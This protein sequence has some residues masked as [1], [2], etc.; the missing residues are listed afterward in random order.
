MIQGSKGHTTL[1]VFARRFARPW[2]Q[3]FARRCALGLTTAVCRTPPRL[4]VASLTI[5]LTTGMARADLT[6]VPQQGAGTNEQVVRVAPPE[7]Y[8]AF[9]VNDPKSADIR[10]GFKPGVENAT[11]LLALYIPCAELKA[12]TEAKTGWLPEWL[13]YETNTIVF[14]DSDDPQDPI[15]MQSRPRGQGAVAQLCIDAQVGHPKVA[16]ATFEAQ[17]A[18]A[19]MRL[20]IDTPV[21]YIGVVGEE[22]GACFL[23]QLRLETGSPGHYRRLLTVTAFM[24]AGGK[25]VYQSV[26]V[27]APDA[28]TATVT[29]DRAKAVARGFIE[30]NR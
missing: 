4:A 5:C 21:I 24:Q 1:T 25:W 10:T 29:L 6:P 20:S 15:R 27:R 16:G 17:V 12:V 14:P 30:A 18:A 28:A 7:G 13:A 9:D 26:R 8:C 2:D 22:P 23:S 11:N 19:Q 3:S